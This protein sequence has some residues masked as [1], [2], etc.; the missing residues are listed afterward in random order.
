M[1]IN[2]SILIFV[3]D[4]NSYIRIETAAQKLGYK[5]YQIESAEEIGPP[6]SLDYGRQLAEPLYGRTGTLIEN[7]SKLRPSLIMFDLNNS[8][9]PWEEWIMILTSVPATRRIP[10]L[11]YGSHVDT[12][13]FM[14]A[15]QS[16]ASKIVPRSKFFKQLTDI[17]GGLSQQDKAGQIE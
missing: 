14:K 8:A 11:C 7:V 2:K 16:G 5:I 6:D 9:I 15:K 4:I 17:I 10:V 3:A 13:S 12:S 1:M